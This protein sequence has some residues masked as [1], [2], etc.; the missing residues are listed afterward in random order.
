MERANLS[1][2]ERLLIA[3][4]LDIN[5]FGDLATNVLVVN[6]NVFILAKSE[7]RAW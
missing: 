5:V 4:S 3:H 7:Q 2:K 1:Q 6:V